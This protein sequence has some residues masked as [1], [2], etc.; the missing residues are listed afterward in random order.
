[1]SDLV[2]CL[3]PIASPNLESVEHAVFPDGSRQLSA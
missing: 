3:I 1:M 2:V